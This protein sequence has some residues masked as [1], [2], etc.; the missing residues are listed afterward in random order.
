MSILF[1]QLLRSNF[2]CGRMP[3]PQ[4]RC[5]A[6]MCSP[7]LKQLLL[8]THRFSFLTRLGTSVKSLIPG[9]NFSV[10]HKNGGTDHDQFQ[11]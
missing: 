10:R 9:R 4:A 8:D 1:D 7:G 2:R 3:C 5:P 6:L 11:L